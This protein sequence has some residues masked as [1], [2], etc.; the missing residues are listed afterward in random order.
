M[1]ELRN[2]YQIL[3]GQPEGKTPLEKPRNRRKDSVNMR[4]KEI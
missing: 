2:A 4:Y 3:F 1:E